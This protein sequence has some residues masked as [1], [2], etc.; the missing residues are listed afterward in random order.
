MMLLY[1]PFYAGT[2]YESS[3][4]AERLSVHF[5]QQRTLLYFSSQ[6]SVDPRKTGVCC[7]L[8]LGTALG[9]EQLLET[10]IG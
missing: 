4:Q 6:T 3:A 9:R 8:S 1:S 5:F 2:W 10:G 7:A